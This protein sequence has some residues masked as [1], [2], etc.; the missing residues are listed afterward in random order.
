[1]STL[2]CSLCV[3]CTFCKFI[4][5]SDAQTKIFGNPTVLHWRKNPHTYDDKENRNTW[6]TQTSNNAEKTPPTTKNYYLQ[7]NG[8]AMGTKMA[9]PYANIFK[10]SLWDR[11]FVPSVPSCACFGIAL[12]HFQIFQVVAVST[13]GYVPPPPISCRNVPLLLSCQKNGVKKPNVM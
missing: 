7:I 6:N 8:T 10:R 13:Q 1:M 9:P 2:S 5:L 4:F 12:I 11:S 3:I